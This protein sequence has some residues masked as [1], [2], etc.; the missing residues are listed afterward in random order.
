M[1]ARCTHETLVFVNAPHLFAQVFEWRTAAVKLLSATLCVGSG[2]PVGP[3]GPMIFI[4]AALGG[5][6]SQG[7]G[8]LRRSPLLRRFW[9]F[10]RFRNTKDKRDFMTAGCAA[11]VA[12]AFGA[13]IGEP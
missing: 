9:P 8:F 6:L 5:L 3:E 10:E 13:P 2:L 7:T 4:G 12:A 11:G 1:R